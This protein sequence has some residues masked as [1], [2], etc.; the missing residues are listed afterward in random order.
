MTAARRGF[1]PGLHEI[2]G[3]GRGGFQFAGLSHVGSI[4][5]LPSGIHAWPVHEA[6]AITA[7]L[8]GPLIAEA[9]VIDLAFIGTGPGLVLPTAQVRAAL[10]DAGLRH[11]FLSTPTATRTYNV[12]LSEGRRVAA[13]LIAVS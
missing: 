6:N 9:G 7:E 13:A 11:E 1:A 5:A 12:L 2:E 3:Y 10:T 8:L 4:L